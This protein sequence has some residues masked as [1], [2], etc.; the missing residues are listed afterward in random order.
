[1]FSDFCVYFYGELCANGCSRIYY[2]YNM[3]NVRDLHSKCDYDLCLPVLQRLVL[4][5][6]ARS[7]PGSL[8]VN[9]VYI[10]FVFKPNK[11]SPV[12]LTTHEPV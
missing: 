7:Q 9:N 5:K 10:M 8:G 3:Y 6:G 4:E 12:Q 1:M 2:I 11:I